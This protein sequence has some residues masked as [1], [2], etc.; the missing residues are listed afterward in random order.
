MQRDELLERSRTGRDEQHVV[1]GGAE[2]RDDAG[3]HE[4]GLAGPGRADDREHAGRI[5]SFEAGPDVRLPAEEA[6]GVLFLVG[7]QTGVGAARR[8]VGE[9]VGAEELRI[10]AQDRRL[11]RGELMPGVDTELLAQALTGTPQGHE[12]VCLMA[13]LVERRGQQRPPTFAQRCLGDQPRR[14]VQHLGGASDAEKR[15]EAE[16][17]GGAA[18]VQQSSGF[19][20]RRLPVLE[21]LERSAAPE[22]QGVA[23][24]RRG[25]VGF[26]ECQEHDAV[27]RAEA[28]GLAVEFKW[29]QHPEQHG[30]LSTAGGARSTA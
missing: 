29:P 19:Q 28:R 14:F 11:E 24:G 2:R 6:V 17:L 15:L 1:A 21:P 5:E 20:R 10:V 23:G 16:V 8:D 30:E 12:R 4:G 22:R 9:R 7:E 26:A 13:G 27:A 25:P 3:A 18:H